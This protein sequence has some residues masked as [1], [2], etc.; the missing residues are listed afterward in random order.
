MLTEE[1]FASSLQ[2]TVEEG[3]PFAITEV[4]TLAA[5]ASQALGC[6]VWLDVPEE[7]L[8]GGELQVVGTV[9]TL[10]VEFARLPLSAARGTVEFGRFR[11][12]ALALRGRPADAYEAYVRWD[13]GETPPS[14]EGRVTLQLLPTAGAPYPEADPPPRGTPAEP[15]VQRS[16]PPTVVTANVSFVDMTEQVV[17]TTPAGRDCDVWVHVPEGWKATLQIALYGR[18]GDARVELFRTG[19]SSVPGTTSGGLF[20]ALAVSSRGRPCDGFEVAL[21]LSSVGTPLTGAAVLYGQFGELGDAAVV[22]QV[23]PP[24]GSTADPVMVQVPGAPTGTQASP[25]HVSVVG[26]TLGTSA[27]PHVVSV[28]DAPLGT[29][30][31]PVNVNVLGAT[32]GT[33]ASPNVVTVLNAPLG[34]GSSPYSVNVVGATLGT[35]ASPNVVTVLG[36][37]LGTSASPYNVEL[38]GAS[39]GTSVAPFHVR[40]LDRPAGTLAAPIYVRDVGL[41]TFTA[42]AYINVV[43]G[44]SLSPLYVGWIHHSGTVTARIHRITFHHYSSGSGEAQLSR[45]T[46][47]SGGFSVTEY[48]LDGSATSPTT[49]VLRPSTSPSTTLSGVPLVYMTFPATDGQIVWTPAPG[50]EPIV[51]PAAG[52]T[53]GLDLRVQFDGTGQAGDRFRVTFEWS[54]E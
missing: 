30:G 45:I 11:G 23:P 20:S 27:S 44:T 24:A 49:Q 37:P 41:K 17:L 7:W 6:D 31:S 29:A 26:A 12:L 25:H 28:L 1:L 5:S 22:R 35:A 36:A 3:V 39:R 52:S 14:G 51:L 13:S 48:P 2:P 42:T 53:R 47:Q 38:V 54:E 10:K 40:D 16:A 50:G 19:I 8:S 9:G 33:T 18:L 21:V 34:N 4:G 46:A 15:V 43:T 32:L